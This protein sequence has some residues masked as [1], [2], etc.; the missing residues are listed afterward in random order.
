MSSVWVSKCCKVYVQVRVG[1]KMFQ[2][3]A[4]PYPTKPMSCCVLLLSFPRVSLRLQAAMTESLPWSA[5]TR[6]RVK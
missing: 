4:S 3:L 5:L 6:A 2:C 1:V